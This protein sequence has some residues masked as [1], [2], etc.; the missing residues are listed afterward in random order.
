MLCWTL[1]SVPGSSKFKPAYY[2]PVYFLSIYDIY[3][4]NIIIIFI[5]QN[6]NKQTTI[7]TI[8]I[9]YCDTAEGKCE[10]IF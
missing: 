4:E 8:S 7:N 3:G 2:F 5:L 6:I 1:N 9:K 10:F